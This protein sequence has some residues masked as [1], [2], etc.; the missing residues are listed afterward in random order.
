MLYC[1]RKIHQNPIQSTRFTLLVPFPS[2]NCPLVPRPTH[3]THF[4]L[5]LKNNYLR[6]KTTTE[7]DIILQ[8]HKRRDLVT[9]V[10][11]PF[12]NCPTTVVS[13]AFCTTITN[14]RTSV[15]CRYRSEIAETLTN[16]AYQSRGYLSLSCFLALAAPLDLSPT[17]NGASRN[18]CTGMSITSD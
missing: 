9:F 16:P 6:L 3:L 7:N 18:Q 1:L 14:N 17:F 5:E 10:V 4:H 13:P 2:P 11:P 15:V 8:G 12:P